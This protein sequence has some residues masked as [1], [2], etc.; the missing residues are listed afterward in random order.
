MP[1]QPRLDAPGA[2][3]HMIVQ[4]IERTSVFR[5]DRDRADLVAYSAGLS[6]GSSGAWQLGP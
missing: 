4:G 3:H 5:A 1:R 6:R 2:L